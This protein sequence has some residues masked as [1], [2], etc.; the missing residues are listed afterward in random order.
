MSVVLCMLSIHYIADDINL[1]PVIKYLEVM[2][3]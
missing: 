3:N 1:L 2:I